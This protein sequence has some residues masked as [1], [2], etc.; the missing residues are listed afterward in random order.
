MSKVYLTN[1]DMDMMTRFGHDAGTALLENGIGVGLR[2][3]AREIESGTYY[4][5]IHVGNKHFYVSAYIDMIGATFVELGVPVG[6]KEVA[7]DDP[8]FFRIE[9]QPGTRYRSQGSLGFIGEAM[10]EWLLDTYAVRHVPHPKLANVELAEVADELLGHIREAGD[11]GMPLGELNKA[12]RR[13]S[14]LDEASQDT[15]LNLLKADG[16][17]MVTV[18]NLKGKPHTRVFGYGRKRD[19]EAAIGKK[20][21]EEPHAYA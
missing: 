10:Y 12:S 4:L 21:Q 14:I 2:R 8:W 11:S 13:F 5:N 18:G 15:V 1:G 19:L 6:C 7:V 3:S 16:V 20:L 9:L 17:S